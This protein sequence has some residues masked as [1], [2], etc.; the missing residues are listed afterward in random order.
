MAGIPKYFHCTNNSLCKNSDTSLPDPNGNLSKNILS[1]LITAA[2]VMVNEILEKSHGKRGEY[3]A[4][5]PA[6]KF[7]VGKHIAESGVTATIRY[8]PKTFPDISL[9]DIS[10]EG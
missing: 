4:L 3:L 7:S 1:S 8:Y 6:Q 9:K 5:T 10:Y 2:N